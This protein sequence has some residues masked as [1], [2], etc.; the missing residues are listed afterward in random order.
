[1]VLAAN[2]ALRFALE[3]AALAALAYWGAETPDAAWAR[4]VLA[5]G[6]PLVAAL[7]WG[8][9]VSPKPW[10]VV[11]AAVRLVAEIAVFAAAAL[12][13][14]ATGHD[15]LAGVLIGAWAANRV[16]LAIRPPAPPER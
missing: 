4:V 12:G 16:M 1:V 9:F 11:P 6:A 13:L 5:V 14:S 10:V 2:L 3:L 15:V 8:A 7:V